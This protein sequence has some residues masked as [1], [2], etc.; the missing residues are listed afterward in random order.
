[1]KRSTLVAFALVLAAV[2]L[3]V[4]LDGDKDASRRQENSPVVSTQLPPLESESLGSRSAAAS[5]AATEG[6]ADE[7]LVDTKPVQLFSAIDRTAPDLTQAENNYYAYIASFDQPPL[8]SQ[9]LLRD[10]KAVTELVRQIEFNPGVFTTPFE[11]TALGRRVCTMSSI[12]RTFP[13]FTPGESL[14]PD[15]YS[16]DATCSQEGSRQVT[17]SIDKGAGKVSFGMRGGNSGGI[18]IIP[19]DGSAYSTAY[20]LYPNF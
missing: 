9:L 17:V 10:E 2:N 3:A 14:V 15:S 12:E 19:I 8:N 20:E 16:A 5:F 11:I 1:M 7:A 18:R 4:W 6:E 13:E